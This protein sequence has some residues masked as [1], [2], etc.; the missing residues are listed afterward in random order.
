MGLL[1]LK[2]IMGCT[3]FSCRPLGFDSRESHIIWRP[4]ATIDTTYRLLLEVSACTPSLERHNA[5]PRCIYFS[6]RAHQFHITVHC[7][8]MLLCTTYRCM[9]PCSKPRDVKLTLCFS[10]SYPY[11]TSKKQSNKKAACTACH[12]ESFHELGSPEGLHASCYHYLLK[13]KTNLFIFPPEPFPT[14]VWFGSEI[15]LLRAATF[16]AASWRWCLSCSPCLSCPSP[17]CKT[18]MG[19]FSRNSRRFLFPLPFVCS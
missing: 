4:N 3:P 1:F 9:V 6:T 19:C 13:E 7:L 8:A 12:W 16:D 18:K 5:T 2:N 14:A 17:S 11:N 10:A 15:L